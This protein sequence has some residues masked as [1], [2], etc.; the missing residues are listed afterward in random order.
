MVWAASRALGFVECGRRFEEETHLTPD[1]C[2]QDTRER[3]S[4]DHDDSSLERHLIAASLALIPDD[5]IARERETDGAR[6]AAFEK[7][8]PRACTTTTAGDLSTSPPKHPPRPTLS[9]SALSPWTPSALRPGTGLL[10]P[11]LF[12]RPS[13][14]HSNWNLTARCNASRAVDCLHHPPGIAT[15]RQHS[16]RANHTR[17]AASHIRFPRLLD[18]REALFYPSLAPQLSH[19]GLTAASNTSATVLSGQLI[20][21]LSS[22]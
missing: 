21:S 5:P 7:R 3:S 22:S 16:K 19:S 1:D 4:H 2:S 8:P 17:P 15:C 11:P 13:S 18:H 14:A 12:P 9:L 6:A 10:A 20:T